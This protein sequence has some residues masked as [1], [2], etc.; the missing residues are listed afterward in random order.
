MEDKRL[1]PDS[2]V[3]PMLCNQKKDKT[4]LV[5]GDK[6]LG[7]NFNAVSCES[8]K[9]FFRRNA[10]KTIRGRCEGKCDINVESRSF[11]K[12]CRLAKCYTVGMR[13]DMI[14]DDNQ[15]K[16]RKQKILINKLRRHG[17]FPSE[18]TY[19]V[20]DTDVHSSASTL[21]A[22][23]SKE[24]LKEQFPSLSESDI[25][26]LQGGKSEEE[27][28]KVKVESKDK[29]VDVQPWHDQENIDD[30]V[31]K[32]DDE[33]KE[34]FL[35]MNKAHE[36]SSFLANTQ[37]RL[38][39][40]PKN[41]TDVFNIAD[42]FVRRII[43]VAKQLTNFRSID[44]DDQIALLKGSVVEIMMLR[45]A[46][47]F[48]IKT[49]TWNLS[50]TSCINSSAASN[51][52]S[53]GSV[54]SSSSGDFPSLPAGLDINKLREAAMKGADIN[55]LRNMARQSSQQDT[56]AQEVPK[57]SAEVKATFQSP[58]AMNKIPGL[59]PGVNAETLKQK[60]GLSID[61][62]KQKMAVKEEQSSGSG[63]DDLRNA[64]KAAGFDVD[65]L[66]RAA[67]NGASFEQL[68]QMAHGGKVGK[69]QEMPSNMQVKEEKEEPQGA[70]SIS[71][72]IL[73][74]ENSETKTMFSTYVKFIKSLMLTIQGDLMILKLLI[75]LSLHSSDRPGI[76][77]TSVVER[78]QELYAN[79]LKKYI[80]ITFP[81]EK[82]MFA[83]C[84]MKL[85]DLRNVN[86]VHT[87]MLLKMQVED[88][89]PLLVEIF[90]LPQ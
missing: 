57:V 17:T 78:Y 82:N 59:P 13:K 41:S 7:Y 64:A 1:S 76:Q 71:S 5:C 61:Q 68:S 9:A 51:V 67:M 20:S 39:N 14:L 29:C 34:A 4:C 84:I 48:N 49:E 6:A 60:Y 19:A 52:S 40:L 12:K 16:L 38:R 24:S 62:M 81:E 58:A 54:G 15:K 23:Q 80:S 75:M 47:N 66:R 22:S 30:I 90:D 53:P 21:L 44:K 27:K 63:I 43:K 37:T 65:A 74:I 45:S 18:D 56:K 70:S 85:T 83:K 10:H 25:E 35:E 46:V 2:A 28:K 87:K 69:S 86:E 26:I 50:T 79:T 55:T 11:C 36:Q 73:K 42:G 77:N 3:G 33:E 31:S 88:I 8:C 89:E 32:M 72:E